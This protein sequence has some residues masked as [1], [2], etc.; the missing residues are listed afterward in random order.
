MSAVIFITVVEAAR[1]AAIFYLVR[2]WVRTLLL[3]G[4]ARAAP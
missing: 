2:R 4:S 3:S 1:A